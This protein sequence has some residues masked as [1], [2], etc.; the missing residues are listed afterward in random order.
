MRTPADRH[1][2][3][4]SM[5]FGMIARGI[6][7]ASTPNAFARA[8]SGWQKPFCMST[9]S[10]PTSFGSNRGSSI[11]R[12]L[13]SGIALAPPMARGGAPLCGDAR[14]RGS[15]S[16]RLRRVVDNA[17]L[18]GDGRGGPVSER[19]D[20]AGRVDA[21]RGHEETAARKEEVRHIVGAP[22]RV[23]DARERILPHPRR[24][25]VMACEHTRGQ[26][27]ALRDHLARTGL[28]NDLRHLDHHEL[29]QRDGVRVIPVMDAKAWPAVGETDRPIEL[30]AVLFHR[31]VL[32]Q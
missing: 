13:S 18:L 9:T 6:A 24:A 23:R 32:A 8:P 25:H 19:E 20:R 28:A 17:V 12:T 16:C 1:I 10:S 11:L 30:Q 31:K 22:V 26:G 7:I 27:R 2:R 21:G 3:I 5:T 15:L 14:T 4:M 29:L